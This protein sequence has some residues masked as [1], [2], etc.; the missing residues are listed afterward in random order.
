MATEKQIEANRRNSTLST[1]PCTEAGREASAQ[2][3]LTLGLFTRRDY[4]KPEERDIYKDFCDGFYTELGPEGHIETALAAEIVAASWRLRRCSEAEGDLADYATADPLLDEST[5]KTRRS[6]ERARNSAHS[7]FHRSLN[8]LRKIQTER[9]VRIATHGENEPGLAECNKVDAAR[10]KQQPALAPEEPG[11]PEF[12]FRDINRLNDEMIASFRAAREAKEAEL[13]SN[14]Q[15]A[16]EPPITEAETEAETAE[17]PEDAAD[18][19]FDLKFFSLDEA[20]QLQMLAERRQIDEDE[21]N[22]ILEA[23]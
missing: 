12:L 3:H 10:K 20:G 5:E 11:L 19:E 2:N 9:A 16:P 6:I 23:A 7:H 21:R 17:T 1:G 13:A 15:A 18:R 4:V 14:C 8:Q 22:A